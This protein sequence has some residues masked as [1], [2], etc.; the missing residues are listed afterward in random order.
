MSKLTG[1][2]VHELIDSS[3]DIK[4]MVQILGQ[5]AIKKLAGKLTQ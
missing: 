4:S 3:Y 5:E 1:K 2:D